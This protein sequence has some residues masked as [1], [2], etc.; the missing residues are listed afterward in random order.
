MFAHRR[1]P[2]WL[3]VAIA[4]AGLAACASGRQVYQAAQGFGSSTVVTDQADGDASLVS[5]SGPQAGSDRILQL[6]GNVVLPI[7]QLDDGLTADARVALLGA[8]A[9]ASLAAATPALLGASVAATTP[10]TPLAPIVGSGSTPFAIAAQG[11]GPP[12]ASISAAG[13]TTAVT[14]TP[15]DLQG[16]LG[17]S[18]PATGL[19]AATPVT[20]VA[21]GV[22]GAASPI[23]AAVGSLPRTLT[24]R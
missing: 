6:S 16:A 20:A 4:A 21:G 10:G 17:A 15:T 2:R 23:N 18:A 9:E 12:G 1:S 7:Y 19:V 5:L 14:L 24:G 11:A 3:T 8:Q 13:A 22:I